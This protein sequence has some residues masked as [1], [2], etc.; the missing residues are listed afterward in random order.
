MEFLNLSARRQQHFCVDKRTQK[1]VTIR[2]IFKLFFFLRSSFFCTGFYVF[3]FETKHKIWVCFMKTFNFF[4]SFKVDTVYFI[5]YLYYSNITEIESWDVYLI[6]KSYALAHS[7]KVNLIKTI[8]VSIHILSFFLLL[9]SPNN[10][11]FKQLNCWYTHIFFCLQ[12]RNH[13]S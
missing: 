10:S 6:G 1:N 12:F 7:L 13:S 9:L 11:K 3:L 2:W 5:F 8:N 4:F